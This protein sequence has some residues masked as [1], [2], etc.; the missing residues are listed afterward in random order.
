M[1]EREDF[2]VNP[3]DAVAGPY[4]AFGRDYSAMEVLPEQQYLADLDQKV[5][6][7]ENEIN[8]ADRGI[9]YEV[10]LQ[11]DRDINK[12]GAVASPK[13]NSLRGYKSVLRQGDGVRNVEF[14]PYDYASFDLIIMQQAGTD[15]TNLPMH[16]AFNETSTDYNKYA[17]LRRNLSILRNYL[18]VT[19]FPDGVY[20]SD[21]KE[22]VKSLRII[23]NIAENLGRALAGSDN[24]N[25]FLER[26]AKSFWKLITFQS[27]D[28]KKTNDFMKAA[29]VPDIGIASMYNYLIESQ[30]DKSIFDFVPFITTPRDWNLEPRDNTPFSEDNLHKFCN[31]CTMAKVVDSLGSVTNHLRSPNTLSARDKQ[32]SVELARNILDKLWHKLD[33][34]DTQAFELKDQRQEIARMLLKVARAYRGSMSEIAKIAPEY[35]QNSTLFTATN[36]LDQITY[37]ARGD[38]A[39][40][41]GEEGKA[42]AEQ[43]WLNYRKLAINPNLVSPILPLQQLVKYLENGLN[44]ADRIEQALK[45]PVREVEQSEEMTSPSITGVNNPALLEAARRSNQPLQVGGRIAR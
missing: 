11:W 5:Q 17:P 34:N 7:E 38:L 31:S 3:V 4:N 24:D 19:K 18:M 8:I 25:S 13:E 12:V 40:M 1:A 43:E 39:S 32:V 26:W 15:K 14:S 21:D 10:E 22:D 20:N 27:L 23:E 2:G 36:A 29:N 42:Q 41:L 33:G 44:E 9:D 6:A 16:P 35:L 30:N 37:L 28:S 45:V